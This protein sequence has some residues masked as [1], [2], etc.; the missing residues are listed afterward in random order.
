MIS[1]HFIC[2]LEQS[3]TGSLLEWLKQ[4]GLYLLGIIATNPHARLSESHRRSLLELRKMARGREYMREHAFMQGCWYR[5]YGEYVRD[6][7]IGPYRGIRVMEP[8]GIN[9]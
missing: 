5:E 6:W 9:G 2:K 7:W 8:Q 1:F 4:L 3:S